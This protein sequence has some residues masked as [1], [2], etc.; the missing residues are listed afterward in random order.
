MLTNGIILVFS[1][2]DTLRPL[3]I[4]FRPFANSVC[5]IEYHKW[6]KKHVWLMSIVKLQVVT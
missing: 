5:D 2:D 6:C 4:Y 1:K 3:V